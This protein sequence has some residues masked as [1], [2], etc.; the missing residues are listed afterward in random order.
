VTVVF[1]ERRKMQDT[2]EQRVVL[3]K[4]E[5]QKLE[6]MRVMLKACIEGVQLVEFEAMLGDEEK[7]IY[8]ELK[9]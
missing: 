5:R 9:P 8:E 3:K 4:A 6:L 1:L 7:E 2:D